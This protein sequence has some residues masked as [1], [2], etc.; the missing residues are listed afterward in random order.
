MI[1]LALMEGT[2][3]IGSRNQEPGQ[4]KHDLPGID[5][6]NLPDRLHSRNQGN[7]NMIYLALIEGTGLIG[8]RNQ[9]P[10]QQW[11]DLPGIDRRNLPDRLQ[12]PG[13]RAT[14]T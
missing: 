11:H 12:E 13:T 10:G 14:E 2:C 9:E 8:S 3:L 1:Y 6:R 5:R 4:Q 7:R